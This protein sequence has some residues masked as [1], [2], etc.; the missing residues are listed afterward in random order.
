MDKQL[1]AVLSLFMYTCT[2]LHPERLAVFYTHV[3]LV[4]GADLYTHV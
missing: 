2:V 3:E 1:F 4:N